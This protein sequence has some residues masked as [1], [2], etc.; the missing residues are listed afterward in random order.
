VVEK[1]RETLSVSKQTLSVSK[2]AAQKFHM[3]RYNLKNM[4]DVE[5][6]EQY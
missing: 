3:E 5:I 6:K 1:V 4:K 2:Q